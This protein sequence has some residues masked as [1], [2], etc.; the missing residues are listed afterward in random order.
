MSIFRDTLLW[1][2]DKSDTTK[3]EFIR[4]GLFQLYMQKYLHNENFC[5]QGID[6][7]LVKER[8]EKYARN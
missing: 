8:N 5:N 3:V 1:I 2:C 4:Y 6:S 7:S